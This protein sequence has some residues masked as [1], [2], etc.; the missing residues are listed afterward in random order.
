MPDIKKPV[1]FEETEFKF[2][3]D[4][5]QGIFEGYASVFGMSILM[6]M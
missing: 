3:G 5:S 2:T 1:S 6:V 4:G